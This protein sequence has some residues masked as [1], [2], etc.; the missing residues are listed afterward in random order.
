MNQHS[1]HDDHAHHHKGHE[2]FHDHLGGHGRHSHAH[3]SIDPSITTS[4][5]GIWAIRWSFGALCVTALMQVVVVWLSSSVAL[6]ADTVHNF[7]D[8]ATV[9]PLWIAFALSRW[10]PNKR[11][12]YGYGRR[13]MQP[14][15][16]LSS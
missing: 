11:F 2:H 10:Q 16:P 8:A 4:A 13:K 5:R 1:H 7:A 14:A 15:L 3:G 12:T 9:V 6:L